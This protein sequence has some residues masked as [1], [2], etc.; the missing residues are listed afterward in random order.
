MTHWIFD[1]QGSSFSPLLKNVKKRLSVA[2][3]GGYKLLKGDDTGQ[4]CRP[5]N[6][7][8]P[9][10]RVN[11]RTSDK[12]ESSERTLKS[13]NR[14][15]LTAE[16]EERGGRATH[17]PGDSRRPLGRQQEGRIIAGGSGGHDA[18]NHVQSHWAPQGIRHQYPAGE[19]GK[20][21]F[22]LTSIFKLIRTDSEQVLSAQPEA[23][24]WGADLDQ[25]SGDEET[26]GGPSGTGWGG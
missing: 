22:K 25:R 7:N 12:G 2:F 5:S 13:K 14:S 6:R 23:R 18:G 10:R 15:G 26:R 8:Q 3:Y 20:V 24:G 16:R 17:R 11:Y 1:S 19:S 4:I 9:T 21:L